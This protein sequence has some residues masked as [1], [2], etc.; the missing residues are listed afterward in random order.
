MGS[1]LWRRA[2]GLCSVCFLFCFFFHPPARAQ[3]ITAS[4]RGVVADPSGASIPG[5]TVVVRN[6]HTG[7]T[8]TVATSRSGQYAFTELP[9]G[10]YSLTI[11]A[12]N[13][14]TYTAPNVVLHVG[15]HR[16]INATLQPGAVTQT[17]T[18]TA[19][20][21]PVQTGSGVQSQ[22]VTGTQVRQ[23]E[24]NNR[25]FEQLVTL[26]PGVSSQL[27]DI[28]GFGLQNTTA[29]SV[30]GARTSANNWTVDGADIN[31]SG[32]NLT[33]LNVPS[34]DAIQEFKMERSSYD[35][36]YGRSGG[37]QINVV[38]KSGGNH[39]HGD[40]YEFFRNDRLNANNF[41]LNAARQP[42][43]GFRYNDFGFTFG[44]PIFKNRTF[45][46]WSEE[47]R[48]TATP[49]NFSG[50]DVTPAELA[51]NFS[52]VATLNPATAPAGCITTGPDGKPDQLSPACFSKNA[53]AYIKA[54]YSRFAPN[55]PGNV[56]V[57]APQAIANY[58]QDMIRLDQHV[59]N[60]IQIFGRYMQDQ[61]PTTE[62]GGLFASEPFPGIASTST[63]APGKNLVAHLTTVISPTVLNEIAF[64]YSWGAINSNITGI[65]GNPA[66]FPGFTRTGFPYA[67]PYHRVPG[68]SIS[69]LIG[70]TP[71]TAPY[72]ERNIDKNLYDNLSIV[73]GAH[74]IRTGISAQWMKKTENAVN[75][76]NGNFSFTNL[77]GNPAFANF[78]LGE[79]FQFSQSNRDI[80]PDLH[81][82]NLEAYIQDDWKAARNL[83]LNLGV[84]YSFFP[85]PRD[86][87][88]ILDN[89]DPTAFSYAAA[90]AIDPATGLFAAT[91]GGAT[92]AT[93]A[94]G[95]IVGG[96]NSPFGKRV[97]P[98][99]AH[100]FAP[101][102]GFSWDPSGTGRMAIRGGYGVFFD[103][104]LN[105]IWEQ[106]QF[107]NPP[108]VNNVVITNPGTADLFDNPSAGVVT[109]PLGPRNL[110]AT[111][112]P[113][114]PTP[115]M[116]NWNLSYE[117]EITPSTMVQVAYVGSKGT[118]LLGLLDLNQ[119]PLPVRA[120]N[121]AAQTNAIRPY[122][123][124][125]VISDIANFFTSNYNSLQVSLNR[126]VAR[127]LN[128][129]VAYTWSQALTDNP[130]D[131][132]TAPQDTYNF[133]NDYGRAAYNRPQILVFNYVYQL[134]LWRRAGGFVSGVLGGWEVSGITTLESGL[135]L[136]PTQLFDPFNCNDYVTSGAACPAGTYPGGIGIDPSPVAPR[137]DFAGSIT[138]AQ[139]VN[140]WFNTGAFTGAIGHFGNAGRGIILGPGWNNWDFALMKNFRVTE[141]LTTQLRGEFFNIFNHTSFLGVNTTLGT[142]SFGRVVSVHD[143]RIVQLGIKFVF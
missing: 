95:I 131:R 8:R 9:F 16:V 61:V 107:V 51:G 26:E 15:A 127:G 80:I 104:S 129:G 22:T 28:V 67:D 136:T 103:R 86:A 88:G 112:T 135:A 62:P 79:A 70:V 42:R 2:L 73:A 125:Q 29:I 97:N 137:P 78:L 24:L 10:N 130:T 19:A 57:S 96:V 17:V 37:G 124:Y 122:K 64:N 34:V 81:F 49:Q 55:S 111:G 119:V 116:Q 11:N 43:P 84:R 72:F 13:F 118:H 27:P 58:R 117:Q 102:L 106:N 74:S 31:D 48:R 35:A 41:L 12:N 94:N 126:R 36:Q 110:H 98:D 75:P 90:P 7:L 5:A 143:P 87:H 142:S 46:F 20:T 68:V 99:L 47:W 38:T 77:N 66:A 120:A 60:S 69:G 52:G 83:T 115:Y 54:V 128:L 92:P 134:P 30:N 114:W 108:F 82:A 59:G 39:F 14:R 139:T 44:G 71:P 132:S 105:G 123:G 4:L 40:A 33:L 21:A 18:V 23:L 76:T 89:F 32:S 6:L 65:V 101:R 1:R 56:F 93:Y 138:G 45:F 133:R 85:T 3:N 63:N 91:P 100:Y 141:R 50:T 53:S 121:P 109:V 113:A 25:N 140:Q